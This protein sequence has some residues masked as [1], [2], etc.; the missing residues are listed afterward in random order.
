MTKISEVYVLMYL[1]CFQGT[2]DVVQ[3]NKDKHDLASSGKTKTHN[4]GLPNKR[5]V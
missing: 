3:N 4:Y 2:V 1:K 5:D